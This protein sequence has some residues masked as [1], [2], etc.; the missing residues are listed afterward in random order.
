MTRFLL[1]AALSLCTLPTAS[2]TTLDLAMSIRPDGAPQTW[3]V[4]VT[5]GA[6]ISTRA[7]G[8]DDW[9]I[10]LDV[11]EGAGAVTVDVGIYEVVTNKAGRERLVLTTEQT[12]T[13][14]HGEPA[15]LL[16]RFSDS[17]HWVRQQ[18]KL[19]QRPTGLLLEVTPQA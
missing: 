14:A 15:A 7:P 10:R 16:Y 18:R 17:M 6:P 8:N 3:T 2:A 13:A 1:V 12:L 11:D 5:G 4:D 9:E 19:G